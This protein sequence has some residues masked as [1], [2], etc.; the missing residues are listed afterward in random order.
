MPTITVAGAS[1]WP[2]VTVPSRPRCFQASSAGRAASTTCR[3]TES[4]RLR[5]GISAPAIPPI[6]VIEFIK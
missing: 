2:N 4:S 1:F 6:V 3:S 5:S